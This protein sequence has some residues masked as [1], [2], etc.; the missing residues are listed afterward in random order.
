[1]SLA[2]TQA[3]GELLTIYADE[4]HRAVTEWLASDTSADLEAM[5]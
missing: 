4:P 3:D 1:M 5:R 2:A